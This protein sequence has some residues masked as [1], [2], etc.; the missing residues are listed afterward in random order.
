M[1]LNNPLSPPPGRVPVTDP[2][3]GQIHRAWESWFRQLYERVGG[4][5][6]PSNDNIS[7]ELVED[8]GSGGELI[9]QVYELRDSLAKAPRT[10]LPIQ[11]DVLADANIE[12]LRGLVLALYKEV[13]ALKQA[14]QS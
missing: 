12:T 4:A 8:A 10:E 14:I 2:R 6:A 3:T 11:P 7:E 1:P 5:A 13:D 9:A